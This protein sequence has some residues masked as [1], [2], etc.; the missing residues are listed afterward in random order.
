MICDDDGD[1]YSNDCD[2]DFRRCGGSS[3]SN[4]SN[5]SNSKIV[6]PCLASQWSIKIMIIIIM[7]KMI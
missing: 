6:I 4:N 3:S 5:S 1:I 2:G 7:L